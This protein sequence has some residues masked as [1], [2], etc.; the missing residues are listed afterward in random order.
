MAHNKISNSEQEKSVEVF[1]YPNEVVNSPNAITTYLNDLYYLDSDTP[2]WQ[3]R[4]RAALAQL[5]AVNDKDTHAINQICVLWEDRRYYRHVEALIVEKQWIPTEPLHTKIL[6]TLK[7]GQI[8][9]R[10]SR[11]QRL[12]RMVL[13]NFQDNDRVISETAKKFLWS[14][15]GSSL[16]ALDIDE[17]LS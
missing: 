3:A 11:N 7:L 4:G 6:V 8:E 15:E 9:T 2:K 1:S 14:L 17:T 5:R 16:G 12:I 13:K 10:W